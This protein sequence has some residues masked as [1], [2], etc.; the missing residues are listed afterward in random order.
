VTYARQIIDVHPVG[1]DID[2]D[3]LVRCIEEC[4]S[5]SQACTACA[6]ACLGEEIVA[7]LRRCITLCGDCADI[8]DATGR[9][10]SRITQF[11]RETARPLLEACATSC[12]ICG[13][14]CEHHAKV[15]GMK[16]CEVCEEACRRCEEACRALVSVL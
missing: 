2:V 4:V 13:A 7:Q 5:C 12:A 3:A 9:T 14:E 8:C 10:V 11:D 1:I 6:D 15:H 16:H